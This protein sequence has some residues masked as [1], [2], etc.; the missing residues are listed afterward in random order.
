MLLVACGGR[1]HRLIE[2][3]RPQRRSVGWIAFGDVATNANLFG[4]VAVLAGISLGVWRASPTAPP[5]AV[6]AQTPNADDEGR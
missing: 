6:P 3:E 2:D 1:F 4:A 5:S